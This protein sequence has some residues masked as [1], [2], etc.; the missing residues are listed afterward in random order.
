[1]NFFEKL[2]VVFENLKNSTLP[3][4]PIFET[5][6]WIILNWYKILKSFLVEDTVRN[7]FIDT[8]MCGIIGEGVDE[9]AWIFFFQS[10]KE[11]YLFREKSFRKSERI[12]WFVSLSHVLFQFLTFFVRYLYTKLEIFFKNVKILSPLPANFKIDPPFPDY[13]ALYTSALVDKVLEK[14]AETYGPGSKAQKI[15]K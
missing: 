9:F 11:P 3:P 6:L 8:M 1:M 15:L 14:I 10:F 5:G 2:W 7:C 12:V 13:S 4:S